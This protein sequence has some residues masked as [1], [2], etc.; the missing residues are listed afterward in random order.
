MPEIP[1][2]PDVTHHPFRKVVLRGLAL[3]APPLLTVVILV[4][5]INTTRMYV[6][7]PVNAGVREALI[8]HHSSEIRKDLPLDD[9]GRRT[10]TLDGRTYHQLD[11]DKLFVPQEVYERVRDGLGSEP[12]PRTAK[13]LY[14][15]YIDLTYLRPWY[16]IPVFL[17]V[18]VLL[19]FLLGKFMAFGIGGY[20]VGR[21]EGI[22]H[23]LPLVRSVY[24]AVKQV[25][26]FF[27]SQRQLQFT[28]VVAV[29]YPRQGMWSLAF[30]TSEGLSDVRAS[31]N[32][33][34][35]GI[36][37]PTSPMPM[38]GYALTVAKREV[39]DLN[40]SIDQ[41]I[42]FIVSCGLVIPPADVQRL[43]QV[44]EAGNGSTVQLS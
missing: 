18:F 36:F 9:A 8:W 30:V 39:L 42:Q 37:I 44:A 6:L 14:G 43:R 22:I 24:S 5:I 25:T 34:T 35:L 3:F 1:P 28:R 21:F 20:F 2:Q 27:L 13:A 40:M 12:L 4:W 26:D 33:P 17:V 31:V 11:D 7:E 29:E 15:R 10:A 41:A 23:R 16:A 32:E 38:T 19:L